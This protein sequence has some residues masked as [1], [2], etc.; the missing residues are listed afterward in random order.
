MPWKVSKNGRF[1][2]E[3][4]MAVLEGCVHPIG[5]V[6]FEH[7]TLSGCVGCLDRECVYWACIE[8]EGVHQGQVKV[9]NP[10]GCAD[11]YYGCIN[12]AT[13]K[14]S[15]Q[16]PD[17]CCR[18]PQV[19]VL[20]YLYDFTDC[21]CVNWGYNP[22]NPTSYKT[23]SVASALN[24]TYLTLVNYYDFMSDWC[25]FEGY[26]KGD[27]GKVYW[28]ALSDCKWS[29]SAPLASRIYYF[30]ELYVDLFIYSTGYMIIKASLYNDEYMD[31]EE[32]WHETGYWYSQF[33]GR[34]Y[35]QEGESCTEASGAAP[36]TQENFACNYGPFLHG[37]CGNTGKIRI[38][39]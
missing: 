29:C 8:T 3:I 23:S 27:W 15:I 39:E 21:S 19:D 36:N 26:Q 5:I 34:Y 6:V 10:G 17:A 1:V 18:Y 16:I 20:A 9:T 7:E 14:F 11:T 12:A 31:C 2:R 38:Y 22:P 33:H 30:D 4:I 35:Y 13:G 25:C 28:Y 24:G 32:G 37:V